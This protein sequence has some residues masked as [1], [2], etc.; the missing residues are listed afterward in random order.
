[1]RAMRQVI[2]KRTI[3][4]PADEFTRLRDRHRG[5]LLDVGTGDGKHALHLARC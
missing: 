1:M 2:G 3:E 5:L 4:L